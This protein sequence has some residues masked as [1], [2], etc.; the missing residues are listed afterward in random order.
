MSAED[1]NWDPDAT[2]RAIVDAAEELF[3]AKGFEGTS[4]ASVAREAKVT[5]SLIHHHYGCKQRLWTEVKMRRFS[6]YEDVQRGVLT[7][8][9]ESENTEE[10]LSQAIESYFN[11]AKNN[12]EIM[13]LLAWM[14]IEGA[15]AV[16]QVDE[17]QAD[18]HMAVK[19]MKIAQENGRLRKDVDARF[20]LM[21]M[22]GSIQH[23]FQ[24]CPVWKAKGLLEDERQ[25]EDEIF[26]SNLKKIIL[27]GVLPF[28]ED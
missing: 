11:F 6:E 12:P 15:P 13:R 18:H 5:K 24:M 21:T 2:K 27:E 14:A 4:M 7:A 16:E 22:L 17:N 28:E 25:K 26:L 10:A 9:A 20:I 19:A 3:I 1:S 8:L 23:W